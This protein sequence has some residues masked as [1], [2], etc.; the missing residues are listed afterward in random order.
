MRGGELEWAEAAKR[1]GD[2]AEGAELSIWVQSNQV[3]RRTLVG[4]RG[5]VLVFIPD[6]V[7]PYTDRDGRY[8]I[9]GFPFLVIALVVGVR[10]LVVLIKWSQITG[11][12]APVMAGILW[13]AI[14]L[15]PWVNDYAPDVVDDPNANVQAI[16][17]V[18]VAEKYEYAAGNYWLTLPIEYQSDRQVVTAVAG[19]PWGVVFPWQ[20]QFPWGVRFADT[21]AEVMAAYP[22]DVA[23]VFLPGDEQVGALRLPVEEYERREVG[24]AVLYLPLMH[25]VVPE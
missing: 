19:H 4:T 10:S 9:V 5:N 23:Y 13:V 8:A 24:G 1:L 6:N 18:L 21:Q 11:Y 16:V 22:S 2:N 20:P 3:V 25:S 14:F 7:N 17:D 15:I 12:V